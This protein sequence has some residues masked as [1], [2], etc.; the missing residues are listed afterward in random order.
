MVDCGNPEGDSVKGSGSQ[1]FNAGQTGHGSDGTPVDEDL[2][3]THENLSPD[4][5]GRFRTDPVGYMMRLTAESSAFIQG[6][7]WRDYN[8]YLGAKIFEAGATEDIKRGVLASAGVR[9]CIAG[10]VAKLDASSLPANEAKRIAKLADDEARA[11]EL[12]KQLRKQ[13]STILDRLSANMNSLAFIKLAAFTLNTILVR[14]YHQG[15]HIKE[16]EFLKM[17]QAAQLAAEACVP[18]IVLPCH[19]SHVDYLVI[20]YIF[21]RLGLA[22]PFVA[23]GDNLD[24]PL[25]GAILRRGGAFF[26]RRSWGDD[27]VYEAVAREYIQ[28]LLERGYNLECFIEG[29]RSRTGKLLNP[30][31]GILGIVLDAVLAGRVKDALMVPISIGYD[32]VVE[33]S[34]YVSE[35]L[36]TPK[37]RE[38]LWGL[39]TNSRIFQLRWGRIDIRFAEPF[40][41]RGYLDQQMARRHFTRDNVDSKLILQTLGYRVMSGINSAS[42]VMPTALVGTTLLTL[43]GRGV[44][45]EELVR[46]VAH[47]DGMPLSEV[48][49]RAI[50]IIKDLIGTR[51]DLIEPVY[52]AINRFELSYYR[53]QV[54]HIF[55]SEGEPLPS[56]LPL[57]LVSVSMY[58]VIKRGGSR[59]D[60]RL[61]FK[62]LLEEVIF[63]SQLLKWDFVYPPGNVED[64]LRLTLQFLVQ[65]KVLTLD[66]GFVGLSEVERASGRENYDF[67]CFLLWPFVESYWLA[68]VSLFALGS[69]ASSG[70]TWIEEPT[71]INRAQQLGKA[72]Y[73]QGDLSYLE[74]INKETLVNAFA[75]LKE[76][77]VILS[78]PRPSRIA[79]HMDFFP[80]YDPS[81][82]I[83][84]QGPLWALVERVGAF[85]RE[86]K[87]RRDNAT[88]STR[89]LRLANLIGRQMMASLKGFDATLSQFRRP[90]LASP[91]LPGLAYHLR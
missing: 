70:P 86:G 40:F 23:A 80:H 84:P 67:Y 42:V 49:S 25:V 52:F 10:L 68:S 2:D 73:Y 24:L 11:Q 14:M 6:L 55:L 44:G 33:T 27:P 56:N 20:S 32:R 46:R 53:N 38:S 4:S 37:E 8:N 9:G 41:L 39:L 91:L 75:R 19:K 34:S 64:N 12:G 45:Q 81:G 89:V 54:I 65:S 59:L 51:A 58:T 62:R 71:Y 78:L 82:A 66:G 36:G 90:Y 48:V 13:S 15:I 16:S 43:R 63:L 83:L 26:I 87:N 74:A 60:Q 79:L 7:G 30:K 47:F 76:M 57:A 72:L 50:K 85:R 35:L 77:G 1:G 29:T 88:V 17:R 5:L 22:L 69:T 21:F 28:A 61:P 31:F 3:G 18:L